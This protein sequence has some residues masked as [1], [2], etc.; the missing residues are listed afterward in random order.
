[1]ST[2]TTGWPYPTVLVDGEITVD[3]EG[4]NQTCECGNDSQTEC[5]CQATSDGRLSWIADGSS[6]PS[7][8][9]VCPVCGRVYPNVTL[10]E[11]Q[12]STAAAIARYDTTSPAFIEDLRRYN[13]D[14]YGDPL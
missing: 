14:A 11:A 4:E 7:E 2:P 5:W 10:F 12:G 9:A 6:D 1:M 3:E 8:F 13:H